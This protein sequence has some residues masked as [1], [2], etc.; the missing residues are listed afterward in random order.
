LESDESGKR[1]SF[2]ITVFKDFN[3]PG[4]YPV[5]SLT[6]GGSSLTMSWGPYT[7][8]SSGGAGSMVVGADGRSGTIDAALND[9]EHV[10]GTWACASVTGP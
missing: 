3:G 8:A 5:G 4:S 7:G 6:D 10:A 1:L 2:T 9:G